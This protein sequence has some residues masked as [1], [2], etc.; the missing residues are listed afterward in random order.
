MSALKK[1]FS[2]LPACVK[3]V[4]YNI[5]L[6]PDLTSF[7]FQ[8]WMKVN[9]EVKSQTDRIVCNAAELKIKEVKVRRKKLITHFKFDFGC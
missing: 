6:K 5:R 3:P 7:T 2:R 9:L 4:H 8:G 1:P